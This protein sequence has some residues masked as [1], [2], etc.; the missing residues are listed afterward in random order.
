MSKNRDDDVLDF[1]VPPGGGAEGGRADDGGT[2][3]PRILPGPMAVALG[4]LV[5]CILLAAIAT[6]AVGWGTSRDF[7][8]YVWTVIVAAFYA[9]GLGIFTTLPVCL[10]LGWLLRHVRRQSLHLLAFFVVPTVLAW[11]IIGIS[12]HSV[13]VPLIMAAAIGLSL[14]AGR[15]AIW[16]LAGPGR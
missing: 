9:A 13:V 5:S 12:V 4:Y 6:V 8:G 1:P 14:A 7:W 11:L 16:R 15:A 2:S 10:L 3:R